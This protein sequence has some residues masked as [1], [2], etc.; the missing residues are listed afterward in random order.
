MARRKVARPRDRQTIA[1]AVEALRSYRLS[2]QEPTE[3]DG[4][5]ADQFGRLGVA[6]AAVE[7]LLSN[8]RQIPPG[9]VATFLGPVADTKAALGSGALSAFTRA[10]SSPSTGTILGRRVD[11]SGLGGGVRVDEDWPDEIVHTVRYQGLFCKEESNF[12]RWS[13]SDEI[14]VVTSAVVVA[15]DASN[16]VRTEKHP[17][18]RE[19][20]GDVD[21]NDARVGPVA[22]C[23]G[24]S[25]DL[26]SLTALVVERDDG[27][28]DAYREDIDTIV[29]VAV[30]LGILYFGAGGALSP[31]VLAGLTE[32]IGDLVNWFFGSGDDPIGARTVILSRA[33]LDAYARRTP[34]QFLSSGAPPTG[35]FQHFVTEHGGGGAVYVVGFDVTRKP[36]LPIDDGPIL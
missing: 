2:P 14:Y 13:G 10:S 11:G 32:I 15:P 19:S 8:S 6:P 7:R 21:T 34:V 36:P 35:I 28:P 24:G 5:V 29:K 23:W 26:V 27:D 33:D 4:F 12:D 3:F 25:S 30:A 31:A 1:L 18:D 16:P 17:L 9:V 20:Y 22:A